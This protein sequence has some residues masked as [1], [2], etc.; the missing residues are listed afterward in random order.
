LLTNYG[1]KEQKDK[2]KQTKKGIKNYILYG[3]QD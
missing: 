1:N 3:T 2:V